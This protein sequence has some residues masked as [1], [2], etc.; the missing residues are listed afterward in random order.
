MYLCVGF[1]NLKT[2]V[3]SSLQSSGSSVLGLADLIIF[4]RI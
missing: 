3:S 2:R 4:V 1:Y